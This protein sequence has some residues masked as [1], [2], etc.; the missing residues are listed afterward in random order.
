[1]HH[2][3]DNPEI[4]AASLE[5]GGGG[6]VVSA[7]APFPSKPTLPATPRAFPCRGVSVSGDGGGRARGPHPAAMFPAALLPSLR[8]AGRQAGVALR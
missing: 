6:W 4:A 1:M 3:F 8:R 2:P 7:D 5:R